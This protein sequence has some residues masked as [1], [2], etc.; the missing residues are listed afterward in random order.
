CSLCR[1]TPVR[2]CSSTAC[3]NRAW[4]FCRS[5]SP[6][7]RW[8]ARRAQCSMTAR[9]RRL[10]QQL[11]HAEHQSHRGGGLSDPEGEQPLRE[12]GF[13]FGEP[14]VDTCEAFPHLAAQLGDALLE[15]R[16]ELSQPLLELRC[17]LSQ[18]LL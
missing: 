18:P 2:R 8:H 13:E 10:S 12:L 9:R 16:V 4:R 5:P 6:P 15:L 11:H 14:L 1:A 17:D 7:T 3:S